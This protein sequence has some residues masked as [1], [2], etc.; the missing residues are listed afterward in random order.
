[1]RRRGSFAVGLLV[2]AVGIAIF[3]SGSQVPIDWEGIAPLSLPRHSGAT[4]VVDGMIYAIGGIEYG[5]TMT[6][7][8][9]TYDVTSGTLVEVYDPAGDAWTRLAELPYPIDMMARRAEGRMWLAAAAHDGKIYTFG[10]ANLNDEVRDTIDVYDI[11]TDRWTA[12]IARLPR[13]LCGLSAATVGDTVYLFGGATSTDPYA[14]Q[15]YVS[16]CYA[17]DP[18]TLTITPLAPMPIARV[19]TSAV[20]IDDGVLVL[21]GISATASA[22]AQI[23]HPE[24]DAWERL[25]PVFWERR[26]WAAAEIDGAMFL[27][28]GRDEHAL[29]SG[30]VDVWVPQYEAWLGGDA[31]S[32]PRED[33]FAAAIGGGLD[34]AGGRNHEGVPFADAERGEP[35]VGVAAAPPPEPEAE[36]MMSWSEGTPMPTP[37]YFGAVAVVDDVIYTIGGLEGQDPTG[38]MVE[39]YDPGR[40]SW[41]SV[42]A[43]PEGRFNM[44]A[45]VLDGIVYVFGGAQ[46][47]GEVTD[48]VY[49]YDPAE[50]GWS[51]VGHLPNA[52]AG[53]SATAYEDRIYLFGGSHS[54]QLYVPKEN[55]Y[56]EAYGFD[57]ATFSFELLPPM[58]VARNM[59]IAGAIGDEVYVIGGMKSPGATACQRYGIKTRSWT[60]RAEMP[61]PRGGAVGVTFRFEDTVAV[62]VI[63]GANQVDVLVYNWVE[64]AWVRG[65][66]F[67]V[68][69]NMSFTSVAAASPE[70]IYVIGGA[71]ETGAPTGTV[72]IG[73]VEEEETAE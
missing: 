18:M 19:M 53:M 10:G 9:S 28:G 37:R 2:S 26:F 13:P 1:M 71:D 40:D 51:L 17:F 4:V 32:V 31:M 62:F 68:P 30:A 27:I 50:D 57:P 15:D 73:E 34:V 16:N 24:T 44:S 65:Y 48:T 42:A 45:A 63:G 58:P 60:I 59:A 52:V 56:S 70:R 72:F 69:R 29:S 25:E 23:Y 21:G 33:A 5:N 38:T 20:P 46:L 7:F 35:N 43:L 47:N 14:P 12:G 61:L 55:Y 54:S 3:A 49:A 6:V 67:G 64:D 39:A 22:G 8:G 36:V 41:E 66:S 11:A